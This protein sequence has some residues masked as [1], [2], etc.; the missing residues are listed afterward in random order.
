MCPRQ[1]APEHGVGGRLSSR[2]GNNGD[3]EQGP[4]DG[5]SRTK[6]RARPG[7]FVEAGGVGEDVVGS[8][9]CGGAERKV[10][11]RVVRGSGSKKCT[12]AGAVRV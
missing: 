3:N 1:G 4:G 9:A 7:W 11:G 2:L 10:I 8:V 6:E 12:L 5:D